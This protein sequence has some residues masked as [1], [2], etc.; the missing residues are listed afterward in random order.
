MYKCLIPFVFIILLAAGCQKVVDAD[1]LLGVAPQVYIQGYLSPQD[2]MF[3]IH[4]SKAL[5]AVGTPLDNQDF[6]SDFLITDAAVTIS[7]ETGSSTNLTYSD[8]NKTYLANANTLEIVTNA[9]Y[10]LKVIVDGKEFNASCTIPEKVVTIDESIDITKDE[11]GG[12]EAEINISFQDFEGQ[13]NFYVLGGILSTTFQ[14]EEQEPQTINFTLF[15]D[16]DEFLTDNL[17]D[18]GTLNGTSENYIDSNTEISA[19][20]IILKVAHVEEILFQNLRA[21]STNS[22]AEGNPFV[23]YSIAPNNFEEEGAVG[24]FAG[25]QLTEKEVTIDSEGNL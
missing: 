1:N 11:F 24:I 14:F 13:R 17:E 18:G 19:T 4:I 5:P 7:D 23:E 8:E 9:R 21:A 6:A 20:K 15:F 16:S 22:D 10:F 12:N 25:Y 2:T 3:R